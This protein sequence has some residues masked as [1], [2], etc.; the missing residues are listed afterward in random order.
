[1]PLLFNEK[2]NY[3]YQNNPQQILHVV[4][5]TDCANVQSKALGKV[6]HNSV[7]WENGVSNS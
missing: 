7:I 6:K 2:E 3:L 1:M 5:N 4:H